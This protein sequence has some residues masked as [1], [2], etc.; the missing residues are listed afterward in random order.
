[1]NEKDSARLSDEANLVDEDYRPL[2]AAAIAALAMGVLS[3]GAFFTVY[4]NVISLIAIAIGVVA[5]LKIKRGEQKLSG[6]GIAVLGIA[7]A[8]MF[9]GASFGYVWTRNARMFSQANEYANVWFDLLRDENFYEAH[10]LKSRFQ[11]RHLPGTALKDIYE[12]SVE[13]QMARM[14]DEIEE[15]STDSEGAVALTVPNS[16]RIE[17]ESFMKTEPMLTILEHI[18]N[19]TFHL[20]LNEFVRQDVTLHEVSQIY[21]FKYTDKDGAKKSIRFRMMIERWADL[22]QDADY[23]WNILR[24]STLDERFPTG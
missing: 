17:F 2:S 11:S 18:D 1:M 13:T 10:E 15:Q 14:A 7:L 23:H 19:G 20:V 4:L 8:V 21:E 12:G 16:Q 5:I 24:V 9:S 6:T 3:I 22:N